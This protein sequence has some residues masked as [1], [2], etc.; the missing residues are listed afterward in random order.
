MNPFRK[1]L[2]VGSAVFMLVAAAGS[3]LAGGNPRGT[4]GR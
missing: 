1:T 3:A 4:T 2:V